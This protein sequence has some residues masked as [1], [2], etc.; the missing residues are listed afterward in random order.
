MKWYWWALIALSVVVISVLIYNKRKKNG[1]SCED[2]NV[3]NIKE[4]LENE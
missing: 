2:K 4:P 1:C 3:D